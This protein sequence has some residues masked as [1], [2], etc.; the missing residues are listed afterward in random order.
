LFEASPSE[1]SITFFTDANI[2][3][4]IGD[5]IG[6][7]IGD[8]IGDKIREN[9]TQSNILRLMNLNPTI[10]A[11]MLAA[12]I[13]IAQRNVEAHIRSLKK[14]GLLERSGTA[15]SG[16]WVVK[17]LNV[18]KEKRNRNGNNEA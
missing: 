3:D 13:G 10:S 2:G 16:Y 12:E 1:I 5:S 4:S 14:N 11:K 17:P 15:K 18:E 7:K 6:D 9:E 8:S